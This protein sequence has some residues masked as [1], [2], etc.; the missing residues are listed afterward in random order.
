MAVA[1]GNFAEL[2]WPG[3]ADLWGNDYNQY[4]PLYTH[5][6]DVKNSTMR[7]EKIQNVTGLG[8]MGVKDEGNAVGYED[9]FQG[10]QKEFVNV[11]YSLG[12]I[13]TREMYEDDQY[14][15]INTIPRMLARSGQQTE[16][17]LAFNHLNRGFNSAFPGADGLELFSASHPLVGGG[18]F[19]N[20][21]ATAA[22]LNQTSLEQ[23]IQEVMDFVDDQSLKLRAQPKC[24]VVSTSFNFRSQKLLESMYVTGSADN[25]KNPLP[26][27]F[28]DRVVSPFLTDPDAWFIITD[29]P[30][31]LIWFW[32]RRRELGRDNEF[33][34]ENL[35]FKQTWRA[36]SGWADPRG[37]FG[38]P[39]A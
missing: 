31:G 28:Q 15:Y 6:F 19:S 4:V 35:K 33:D 2:L 37:A 17:T 34:T 29:V 22:D 25:D 20:L 10:F 1:S 36:S 27:L 32:R 23:A 30:L 26:G 7:F 13:V 11:T 8:L 12:S 5:C 18:T 14:Q 24:L 38:T 21:L 3:I 9:P 39:G 16:E